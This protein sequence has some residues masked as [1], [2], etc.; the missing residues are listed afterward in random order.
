MIGRTSG[1]RG[2]TRLALLLV[3][4]LV[5]ILWWSHH[6]ILRS[7]G[8]F[9]NVGETPQKAEAA[10]VLAGGWTGERVIRAGELLNGGF[11]P[12]ILISGAATFYGASECDLSRDFARLKRIPADRVE[13]IPSKATSTREEVGFI[14]PELRRR[15]IHRCLIVSVSTHL[16][17]ARQLFREAAPDIEFHFI[18]A[19]TPNFDLENWYQSREGRKWVSLEWLKLVTGWFGV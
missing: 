3:L 7:A 17:R 11:V 5:A 13:C 10:V 19:P 16:R 14:V 1:R 9:L 18:A 12:L 8:E 4:V 6:A 2:F 15:G